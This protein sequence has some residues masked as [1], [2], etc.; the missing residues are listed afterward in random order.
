MYAVARGPSAS[1]FTVMFGRSVGSVA[2]P[3][4]GDLNS[5]MIA[6]T[7]VVP[8]F[9]GLCVVAGVYIAVLAAMVWSWVLPSGVSN[10]VLPPS[11]RTTTIESGCWCILLFEP[12]G[13][14]ILRTRTEGLSRTTL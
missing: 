1:D 5:T 6:S 12:A 2:V 14:A 9:D 13:Y 8:T 11:E 3:G 7:G 10:R 4:L